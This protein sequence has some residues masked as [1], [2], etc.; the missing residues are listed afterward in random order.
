M[1]MEVLNK[2]E[3]TQQAVAGTLQNVNVDRNEE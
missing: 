3:M 2:C 1:Y